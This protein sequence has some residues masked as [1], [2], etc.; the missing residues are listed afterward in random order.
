MILN[1][2]DV[3]ESWLKDTVI[4]NAVFTDVEPINIYN[5]WCSKYDIDETIEAL[6]ENNSESYIEECIQNWHMPEEYKDVDIIDY[7]LNKCKSEK[8]KLRV[9]EELT[10]F[11][12][13][14]MLV[15]LKFLNYLVDV[16]KQNDIVL[17]VG[18]GS[19]V[20]SYCLYLLGVHRI[21]SIKYELDI[22]EFLK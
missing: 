14:G 10:I 7:L 16:C 2:Q 13:R 18:R 22:K 11:K 9:L 3:V 20:A 15:V 12:E 6:Y 21:D 4:S 19:S 8:E 1:E 17:G 5:N